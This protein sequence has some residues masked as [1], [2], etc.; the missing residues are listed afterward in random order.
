MYC[1]FNKEEEKEKKS[2][3]RGERKERRRRKIKKQRALSLLAFSFFNSICQSFFPALICNMVQT[4]SSETSPPR[5]FVARSVTA[6]PH[7]LTLASLT[8][9]NL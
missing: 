5:D 6:R 8:F 3:E 7:A 9:K 2:R 1:F 4:P